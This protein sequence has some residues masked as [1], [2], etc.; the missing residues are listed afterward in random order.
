M[1]NYDRS[2]ANNMWAFGW[3]NK[4][5]CVLAHFEGI[6]LTSGV[7]LKNVYTTNSPLSFLVLEPVKLLRKV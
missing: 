6:L 4:K 7:N 1:Y 3:A 5:L 2:A